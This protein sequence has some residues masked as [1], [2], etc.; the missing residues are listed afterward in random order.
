MLR[1]IASP[2]LPLG[3][4][5]ASKSKRE[6]LLSRLDEIPVFYVSALAH[7]V[8]EG[9]FS[10]SRQ[11]KRLLSEYFNDDLSRTGVPELREFLTNVAKEYLSENFYDDLESQVENEAR[12]LA[13]V[14]RKS[15]AALK[16]E[17]AGGQLALRN[18]VTGV[19]TE[20]MP[21]L[22]T[23]IKT[24]CTSFRE[25][26]QTG[27]SGIDHRLRQTELLSS[28][29][30]EDKLAPWSNYHW[31]S[32]RAAARKRGCHFTGRGQCI[33]FAEDICS[34]LVDDLLIAWSYF[35]DDLIEAQLDRVTNNLVEQLQFKLREYQNLS[36]IPEVADAIQQITQQLYGITDH[37]RL[38]LLKFVT[39]KIREVES[40]RKPAKLIADEE[41]AHLFNL[42]ANEYGTGCSTRMQQ[43]LL[44]EAPSAIERIKSRVS[45]L[46]SGAVSE[47]SD[48]CCSALAT[49]GTV[50]GS[51][52]ETAITHVSDS[53]IA[54]DRADMETRTR[55]A[56][57]ALNLLPAP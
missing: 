20:L 52:I 28:R 39:E 40:I 51:K 32:L 11:T 24:A 21:W 16:A 50:A 31:A 15:L 48:S 45:G 23:E 7:E 57:T 34:V 54:R 47:L 2:K 43:H 29:R 30:I 8:F 9:R 26:A 49:F 56:E 27:S 53:L 1:D 10:A 42:I 14:F 25:Q 37:Q 12:H 19:R 3:D 13:G 41:F 5:A 55:I 36:E 18:V 22:D 46:V 33:D 17:V 44:D 35:R 38:Q 6:E 4:D